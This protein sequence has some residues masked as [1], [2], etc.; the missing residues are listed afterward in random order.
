MGNAMDEFLKSYADK[1][2]RW[3]NEGDF[4]ISSR[5][6]PVFESVTGRPW[7]I[8][9]EQALQVLKGARS[10]ALADC[11]CRTHY[12]RC[13]KPRKVC[14]LLDDFGD[15]GVER[16]TACRITLEKAA[17]VLRLADEHG[18]VHMTLYRPGG[19]IYALC[20]CC[21]CCC[22]DLQLMRRYHRTDLVAR[23][24]YIAVTDREQCTDCGRCI[25]R[26]AFGAREMRDGI[27]HY[28]PGA[29]LG[30]GL[31]VSSCPAGATV[32]ALRHTETR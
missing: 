20:N 26:C 14:F 28:D 10:F 21:P 16:D 1:Y 27:M 6:I 15:R 8:P 32:M 3:Q 13:D 23:S 9:A 22:H 24:D 17:E 18:L 12:Q 19:T 30:C 29:C 2:E 7:V 5:V 25:G 11:A 31:C 4:I